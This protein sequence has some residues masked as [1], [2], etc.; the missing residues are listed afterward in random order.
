MVISHYTKPH[1]TQMSKQPVDHD[2]GA[3]TTTPLRKTP[4][5]FEEAPAIDEHR[6]NKTTTAM[7]PL[8][9]RP[10]KLFDDP[11]AI[12]E[13]RNNTTTTTPLRTTPNP[14]ETTSQPTIDN[15]VDNET[16]IPPLRKKVKKQYEDT[17][18]PAIDELL[19]LL[20]QPQFTDC[21]DVIKHCSSN[22]DG[23]D[24]KAMMAFLQI[25]FTNIYCRNVFQHLIDGGEYF[26]V[27]Q[28][29]SDTSEYDN[30]P[31]G[32]AMIEL[33]MLL[34]LKNKDVHCGGFATL[35]NIACQTP[36]T[37]LSLKLSN[38]GISWNMRYYSN[39]IH[40]RHSKN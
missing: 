7:T 19:T 39:T 1:T 28:G 4:K 26:V 15:N 36:D 10:K 13:H 11:S 27:I 38:S 21:F 17:L 40:K 5:L 8:R 2:D 33:P 22:L 24:L 34:S 37:Y 18:Q 16:T 14:L 25:V 35:F 32:D 29:F 12:E 31:V 6:D 9:K 23:F 20:N 3:T 30:V